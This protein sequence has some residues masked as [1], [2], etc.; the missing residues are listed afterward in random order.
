M[1]E[2]L[3]KKPSKSF[4]KNLTTFQK[5]SWGIL[6][7]VIIFSIYAIIVDPW[8]VSDQPFGA[9]DYYYT[10]VEGFNFN[11]SIGTAHPVLFF[12]LFVAWALISW[13]FLKWI[14]SKK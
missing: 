7:I 4:G 10:D 6:A 8:N 14:E 12:V 5:I 2:K 3:E 9:G 13:Y 11:I 1:K